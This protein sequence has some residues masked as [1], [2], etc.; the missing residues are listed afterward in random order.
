MLSKVNAKQHAVSR[1][2]GLKFCRAYF[3]KKFVLTLSR[4]TILKCLTANFDVRH[5]TF[6][7]ITIKPLLSFFLWTPLNGDTPQKGQNLTSIELRLI[8]VNIL[9][10]GGLV[11]GL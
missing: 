3:D 10:W 7:S 9:G 1:L 8:G 11:V 5:A 2:R 4:F 6:P